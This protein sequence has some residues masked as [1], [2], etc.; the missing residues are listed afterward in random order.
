MADRFDEDVVSPVVAEVVDVEEAFDATVD[1]R[2]QTDAGGLVHVPVPEVVIGQGLAV[3]VIA[4]NELE[5]MGG[6]GNL[7]SRLQSG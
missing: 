4:D 5:Q 3:H 6:N 1:E 7:S 2:L